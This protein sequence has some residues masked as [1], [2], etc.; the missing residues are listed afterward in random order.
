MQIYST[1][2]VKIKH[3][4]S[5]FKDTVKIYRSAVDLLSILQLPY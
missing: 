1:Y 3:Y 5:I 4:N 2:P